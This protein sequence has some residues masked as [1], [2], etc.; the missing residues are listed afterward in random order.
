MGVTL[1]KVQRETR[2]RAETLDIRL[3]TLDLGLIWNTI[4]DLS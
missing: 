1:S 4:K 3:W 2:G